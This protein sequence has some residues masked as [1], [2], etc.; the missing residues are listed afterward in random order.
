MNSMG[1]VILCSFSISPGELPPPPPGACVGRDKFIKVVISHAENFE[2]IALM[3][4]GGIGKTTIA[5]TVLHHD[6]IKEKFGDNR[7]FIRCDRPASR[8]QF[9]SQL[10]KVIGTGIENPEDL[11]S[12]WPFLSSRKMFL[13]LDNAESILDPHGM[14]GREIYNVIEELGRFETVCLCITSRIVTVPTYFKRQTIPRLSKKSACKI[15]YDIYNNG[16]QS[17]IINNL[18]EQLDFHAL[19]ITLLATVA[20]HNMWDYDRL[21]R[22]WEAHHTDVLHTD[23]NQSLAAT[24]E[25][26]LTSPMFCNLNPNARDLLSVIAFYPQG[27]NEAN[28]DWLFPTLSNTR[29]IF[30]KFCVLSLTYRVNGFITMLAPLR[31]YLSPRNP[32]L[33]PL[34]CKTEECYFTRLRA[35]IVD[36]DV[37]NFEDSKWIKSEDVNVEHLLNVLTSIDKD[38][39]DTWDVC[40]SFLRHLYWHKRRLVVLGPKI[41]ELPD[42]HCSKPQGLVQLSLLFSSVGNHV[43]SKQLLSDA[44]ELWRKKEDGPKTGESLRF[45]STANKLLGLPKAG[46]PQAEEAIGIYKNLDWKKWQGDCLRILASLFHDDNQL[47]AAEK[48]ASEAVGLLSDKK[49]HFMLCK[50]YHTL[51]KI[52]HST[53]NTEKAIS[54]FKKALQIASSPKW[55]YQLFHN[56]YSLAELYSKEGRFSDTCYH[57]ECAKSHANSDTDNYCLGFAMELQAKIWYKEDRLEE[58][59]DEIVGAVDIFERLGATKKIKD[60]RMILWDIESKERGKERGLVPPGELLKTV[61]HPTLVNS[62]FLA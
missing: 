56:H 44:L 18:L 49:D 26:S 7:R 37:P 16:G 45:L 12:L 62:L 42:N 5:L 36:P 9:L 6:R 28:L 3:G 52:Y 15:F 11:T 25:L 58:A 4:A 32:R 35:S 53:G 38:S 24:I 20:T 60:C 1:T 54:H 31:D 33:S 8:A 40:V 21:A 46:I 43:E 17:N 48:A 57:I 13:I 14:N 59:R 55:H 19:S 39:V 22:E 34:L 27:V 47:D 2:P 30:D 51:G 61:L 41:K 50:C 29:N 23:Y 10:S